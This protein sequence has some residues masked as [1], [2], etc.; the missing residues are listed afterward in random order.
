M[1][2]YEENDKKVQCVFIKKCLP[3]LFFYS[4]VG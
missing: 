1:Q 4:Y 3:Q 2:V